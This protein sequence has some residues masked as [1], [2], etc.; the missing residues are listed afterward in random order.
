MKTPTLLFIHG[1]AFDATVFTSLRKALGSD[2][3]C[4]SLDFAYF[5]SGARAT[6]PAVAP[7]LVVTHSFGTLWWLQQRKLHRCA[8]QGLVALNGFARFTAGEGFADGTPRRMLERMASRLLTHP[9]A[10]LADFRSRCGTDVPSPVPTPTG[11]SRLE[12][13]LLALRDWDARDACRD[14][15]L[16]ALDA[17]DDVIVP[18]SLQAQAYGQ[19][20]YRR[21]QAAPGTGHLLPT[22]A[23]DWCAAQIRD[24]AAELGCLP[25]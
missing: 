8:S 9:D 19:A 12:E 14:L 1:W 4:L 5:S 23:S 7:D 24:F 6:L 13:D 15:P 20:R 18:P 16:L 22:R 21:E 3:A 17:P 2:F 11:L 25:R 10:V